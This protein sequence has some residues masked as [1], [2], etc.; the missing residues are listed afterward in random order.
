MKRL[1]LSNS[2]ISL[3]LLFVLPSCAM[4]KMIQQS[5]EQ[6]SA[7]GTTVEKKMGVYPS[8][9]YNN[10]NGVTEITVYFEQ[11][12]NSKITVLE[13]QNLVQESVAESME[14]KPQK[15]YITINTTQN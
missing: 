2:L 1:K 13:L 12:P 11:L 4:V 10:N 6:T 9:S 15:L 5:L 7:I 3:L 14:Q 8:I